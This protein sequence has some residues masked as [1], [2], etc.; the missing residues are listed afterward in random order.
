MCLQFSIGLP[1][2]ARML[3]QAVDA[4]VASGAR[5]L[6]LGSATPAMCTAAVTDAVLAAL[7]QLAQN[8]ALNQEV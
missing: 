6:D 5:T 8:G 4:V 1:Q 3:R 7:N 2:E